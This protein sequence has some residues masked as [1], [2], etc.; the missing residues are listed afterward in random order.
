MG[1]KKSNKLTN[2]INIQTN[3]KTRLIDTDNRMVIAR[4][5]G[6]WERMKRL[7]GVKCTVTGD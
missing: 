3:K 6:G 1:Y 7:K 4:G 5:E 2:K